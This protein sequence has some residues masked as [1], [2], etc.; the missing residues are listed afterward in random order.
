MNLEESFFECSS[1]TNAA[2]PGSLTNIG[3]YSFSSC[4]LAQVQIPSNLNT[5]GAFAFASCAETNLIIPANVISIS[6]GAFDESSGLVSV[7]ILG[8]GIEIGPDAFFG[9]ESLVSLFV[10]GDAPIL[11]PS[12]FAYDTSATAFYLV[13][14][15]GWNEFTE[16]SGV[17]AVLWNPLIQ[18]SDGSFGVRNNQFGF[19]VTGTADIP[20]V[21]EACTNLAN[22]VWI[23][24]QSLTLTN[25]LFYFSDLQ[26]TNYPARYYRISSP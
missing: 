15:S 2:L 19:D 22:S 5:I 20:I 11:G 16:S 21:V 24:L 13:G 23:P 18:T 9:C 4:P 7:T 1:L 25:G 17:P 10:A 6:N 14:T 26:W 12:A 8:S 3:D